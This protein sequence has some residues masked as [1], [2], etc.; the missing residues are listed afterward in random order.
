MKEFVRIPIDVPYDIVLTHAGYVGRDHYQS[1]KAAVNAMPAVKENGLIVLFANNVDAEPIGSQEYKT[2]L[3]LF[4]ILGPDRYISIMKHPDWKFT[5]DQWEPE[6][7]GK[8]IL[9]VGEAGLIY[10]TTQ[11]PAADFKIIPG[12]SGWECINSEETFTSGKE[13]A[14]S[15][16][17]NAVIY[18]ANHPRFKGK[19]PTMAFIEEGPYAIPVQV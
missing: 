16:L 19:K 13:T 2:L 12:I 4:K 1:V 18:A 14:T 17:Q 15:M 3:H 7:W 8:P 6:M 10:C 5:K 11:I 9:K